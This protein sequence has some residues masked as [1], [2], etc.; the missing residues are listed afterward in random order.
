MKDDKCLFCYSCKCSYRIVSSDMSYD[1][2]S[3]T[4]HVE[5]LNRH[6]DNQIPKLKQFINSTGDLKRGDNLESEG[7]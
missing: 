4:K 7:E 1:E 3:C 2:V 5:D 6:S